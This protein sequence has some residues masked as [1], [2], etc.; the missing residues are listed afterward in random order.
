M[1][2]W[3]NRVSIR[4]RDRENFQESLFPA[5]YERL[6]DETGVQKTI[7]GGVVRPRMR[8][9]RCNRSIRSPTEA[10]SAYRRDCSR[11]GSCLVSLQEEDCCLLRSAYLRRI[12]DDLSIR[13][14]LP[15]GMPSIERRSRCRERELPG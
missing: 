3:S 7:F 6:Q 4:R 9:S 10:E 15:D 11:L 14:F 5:A 13:P 2:P 12:L 8:S 1:I